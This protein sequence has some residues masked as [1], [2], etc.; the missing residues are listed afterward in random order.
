MGAIVNGL[1]A[2]GG[3]IPYGSTFLIFSDYMRPAIRLAALMGL[4]V[5]HVFTHDS[6][7]LGED[8]PTHQPI[9]QLASLRAIPNLTLIRP[10]DANEVAVAWQVAVETRK[11]PVLFAL[12]RQKLP[13]LD[14]TRYASADGVRRG[15]YVLKDA[16]HG[17]P[18]LILIATGSEV[19]LIVEAA[20]KLQADGVAVR[21]VSMPSWDLFD[22]QAKSYRDEVL[23]PGV[24]ATAGGGNGRHPRLAPLRGR[25]RRR[26]G[27][28]PFR[29]LRSGRSAAARIRLHRRERGEAGK[30]AA[31]AVR[32]CA[33]LA[34]L[35]RRG[36]DAE[37]AP[38]IVKSP[39][40]LLPPP[41]GGSCPTG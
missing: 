6:I 37:I 10:A 14:R 20:E 1:A 32:R 29:C 38:A 31:E 3:F 16:P 25:S 19:S 41:S 33:E 36:S 23:P 11:R 35:T 39:R 21:C 40:S 7:A 30:G 12:S 27:H 28:R 2:H 22:A 18:A 26:A 8:G 15:A 4:H 17:K 24:S 9:E 13:T 34:F 5:V